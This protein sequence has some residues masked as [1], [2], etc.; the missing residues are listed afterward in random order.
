MKPAVMAGQLGSPSLLIAAWVVAGLVTLFGALGNAELAAMFPETGGQLVFFRKIYGRL[1]SF[2]YG[3]AAFAVFNT[4]GNASIA[5]VCSGYA[6]YFLELPR[7]TNAIE[8]SAFLSLPGIGKIFFLENLGVKML[9]VLLVLFFTWINYKSV[10]FG[11]GVQ[12]LLT[13]LKI[14]A[15]ALLAFGLFG[16]PAGSTAH[17]SQEAV[18]PSG[19]ALLS[20]FMAAM[21]GAFWAYDGWNNMTFIAGEVR[22]PQRNIPRS[23]LLGIPVCILVYCLVNLALVYIM[24]VSQMASSP[25]VASEAATIAWG[26]TGAILITLLVILSTLGTTNS[27]ILA[28]A[29]LTMAWSKDNRVFAPAARAHR[30]NHTPGNAL[31]LNAIWSIVLIMSGSFDMLTDMLVFVSWFFY[32]MSGVALFILRFRSPE[33]H[34]PYR[35]L[36]Y[37][38]LPLLFVLFGA[39]FLVVTLYSDIRNYHSGQSPFVHSLFGLIITVCGIPLYFLSKQKKKPGTGSLIESE[40]VTGTVTTNS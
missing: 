28:T 20:A 10:A 40:A 17:F 15:I 13:V 21:A 14:A 38:L 37:P 7:L 11:S 36:G 1:F 2:V 30:R 18:V 12:R 34:R 4:A 5:Y 25:F 16:S 8:K 39:T 26:S 32:T 35:A 22:N 29:R 19:F 33:L 9:T 23:L 24:P 3:W 6:D 27:N 31:W